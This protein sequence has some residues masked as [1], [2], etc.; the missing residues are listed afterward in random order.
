M[1]SAVNDITKAKIRTGAPS[2]E[3][4]DNFDKI[5]FG[6]IKL[7]QPDTKCEEGSPKK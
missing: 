1:K 7:D 3:Y 4:M 6:T 2:K 5:K